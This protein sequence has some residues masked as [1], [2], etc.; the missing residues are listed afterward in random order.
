MS[1][2][3]QILAELTRIRRLAESQIPTGIKSFD[4]SVGDIPKEYNLD[5]PWL[6]FVV[7]NSGANDVYV[8]INSTEG[9]L[10]NEAAIPGGGSRNHSFGYPIVTKIILQAEAGA[11]ATGFVYGEEGRWA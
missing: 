1:I 6:G 4:Y 7:D 3:E 11:T 2:D 5:K 9:P 10:T 8:K